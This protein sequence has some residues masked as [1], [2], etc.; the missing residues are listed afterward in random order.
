MKLSNL[1]IVYKVVMLLLALGAVSVFAAMFSST[2][3]INL[4]DTYSDLTDNDYPALVALARAN[5]FVS[6]TMSASWAVVA[7]PD[8][9][10][11]T[12]AQKTFKA[13]LEGFEKQ[14]DLATAKKPEAKA[15]YDAIR[16][17]W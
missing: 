16:K 9:E 11:I 7:F 3:L 15:D 2:K 14:M 6:A 13:S 12:D 4:D 8:Q 17:R 10:S 5:R 1:K